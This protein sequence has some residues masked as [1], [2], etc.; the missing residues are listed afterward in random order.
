M[1]VEHQSQMHNTLGV[2]GA[3]DVAQMGGQA[4]ACRR[5]PAQAGLAPAGVSGWVKLALL[6]L[7][8]LLVVDLAAELGNAWMRIGALAVSALAP[9]A[10]VV[11]VAALTVDRR[12]ANR[13]ARK[14]LASRVAAAE[15]ALVHEEE[16]LH[17]LRATVTG[18]ALCQRVLISG[19]PAR[20]TRRRLERLR[21]AEFERME[22]LLADN[23][24][25]PVVPVDLARVVDPLVEA[26]RLRG[27]AVRWQ[28]TR[29]RASGR[30]DDIAQIAHILLENAVRHASGRQIAVEVA[31]SQELIELRVSDHGPGVPPELAPVVFERGT[32]SATSPGEGIGL[33]VARR[34]ARELGGDLLLE[35]GPPATG[36]VFLLHLPQLNGAVP[37][38]APAE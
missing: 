30:A 1:G 27:H 12:R 9:V 17:E 22:R 3:V 21:I 28:G 5:G 24:C 15:A 37:C 14:R 36:A 8:L 25:D 32:R 6:V 31:E 34:L 2:V 10:V 35:T 20:S 26:V 33:H 29:C 13:E 16:L 19:H 11:W 7:A 38:P 18:I 4:L 23:R